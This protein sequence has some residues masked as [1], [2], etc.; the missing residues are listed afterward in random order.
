MVTASLKFPTKEVTMALTLQEAQRFLV[1]KIIKK[2]RERIISVK[3]VYVNAQGETEVFV[4][5][6]PAYILDK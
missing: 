2:Q 6:R 3:S 1:N 4:Y 5:R